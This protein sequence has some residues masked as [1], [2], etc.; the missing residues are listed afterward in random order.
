MPS[1]RLAGE[2]LK[3]IQG[4]PRQEAVTPP[5]PGVSPEGPALPAADAPQPDPIDKD[6]L[7]GKWKAVRPDGSKFDL[8]L[9]DDGKFTWKFSPPRQKGEEFGGTWSTEGPVLV[10]QRDGG[11]ALPGTVTFD[12]D[13]KF[14]FRMVGAPPEDKGLDF[15][16]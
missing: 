5:D 14:N 8:R 9:T 10:L 2:L 1:D 7:P 11:G 15:N 12:G 16:N 3:M 6:L 13:G 4:P